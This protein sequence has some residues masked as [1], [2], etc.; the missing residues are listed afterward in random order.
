MDEGHRWMMSVPEPRQRHSANARCLSIVTLQ[1]LPPTRR[2]PGNKD[3]RGGCSDLGE[4][5]AGS[6]SPDE[7]LRSMGAQS[8]W[9]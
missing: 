8:C 2:A 7:N 4:Q 9:A 6:V 5:S 3:V 1:A